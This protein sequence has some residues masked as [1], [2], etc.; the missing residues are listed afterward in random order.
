MTRYATD[1]FAFRELP[2]AF[3]SGTR[4]L[5]AGR[6]A[7]E[8]GRIPDMIEVDVTDAAEPEITYRAQIP[9]GHPMHRHVRMHVTGVDI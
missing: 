5:L 3:S 7:V 8:C 2:Y 4:V 6:V 1:T 9:L